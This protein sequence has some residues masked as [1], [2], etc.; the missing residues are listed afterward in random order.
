MRDKRGIALETLAK[1]LIAVGILVLM[2][3]GYLILSRKGGLAFESIK[4]AFR[5]FTGG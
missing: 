2:V 1:W 4:N 3:V 5:F